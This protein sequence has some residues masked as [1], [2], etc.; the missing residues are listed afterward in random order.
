MKTDKGHTWYVCDL[1]CYNEQFL[2]EIVLDL[3]K[4]LNNN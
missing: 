1:D 2:I 3:H 4:K